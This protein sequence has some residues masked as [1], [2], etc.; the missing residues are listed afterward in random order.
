MADLETTIESLDQ[1]E[2]FFK[3]IG[4]SYFHMSR[5]ASVRFDEYR[6][7]HITD[8]QELQWIAEELDRNISH[9]ES[10]RPKK[11]LWWAHSRAVALYMNLR[12]R[13]R[14]SAM[15]N[16]YFEK[17]CQITESFAARLHDRDRLIVAE[18]ICG[19]SRNHT[20]GLIKEAFLLGKPE[21]AKKLS[22][23]VDRLLAYNEVDEE[24][25]RRRLADI[26]IHNKLR[27]PLTIRLEALRLWFA[28]RL[29]DLR[30]RLKEL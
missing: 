29:Q 11:N 10:E 22:A 6:A 18:T 20:D 2:A 30:Y 26:T 7:L 24:Q 13:S 12:S 14:H 3:A 17:L 9:L 5:E 23:V 25:N 1:A 15:L 21:A 19:R 4:C 28:D 16:N 27:S 8:D